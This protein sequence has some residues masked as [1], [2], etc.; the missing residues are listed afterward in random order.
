MIVGNTAP[1]MFACAGACA[2]RACCQIER[3]QIRLQPTPASICLGSK[4]SARADRHC[5]PQQMRRVS[6]RCPPK[7]QPRRPQPLC[8][9]IEKA[10]RPV[11]SPGPREALGQWRIIESQTRLK[12]WRWCS[13][14]RARPPIGGPSRD[15]PD[16][17]HALIGRVRRAT[18]L[19]VGIQVSRAEVE[20]ATHA[21]SSVCSLR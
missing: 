18:H 17:W 5:Q 3:D 6:A 10:C 14:Q 1:Q 13:G 12:C 4:C 21:I 2:M 19:L 8:A 9:A 11:S 16:V 20:V 7:L 15:P